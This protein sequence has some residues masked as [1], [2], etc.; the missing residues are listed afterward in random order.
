MKPVKA[1]SSLCALLALS[2]FPFSVYAQ[3]TPQNPPTPPVAQLPASG[4]SS[5]VVIKVRTSEV[6]LIFTVT[7]KHTNKSIKNLQQ[8]N[9]GLLDD[10][11]PPLRVLNFKQQTNLPLRVGIL[12]DTSSSVR[13]RFHFEQEAA[14]E[15]LLEILGHQDRA[16]VE[17]FDVGV[18]I[19][20][21]FTGNIDKL[22]QGIQKLRPGGGTALY[23]AIYKTCRDQLLPL[24]SQEATRRAIIL[25]SDGDDIYSHA[26]ESDAV[27]MCQRAE[28]IIYAISTNVG[29][30]K[31]KG[32]DVLKR[33]S[34]ETGGQTFFPK[35]IEDVALGFNS[36][37]DEL[38]SQYSLV[39]QPTD[40]KMDGAFRTIYLQAI[41][42]RYVV[43]VRKGYFAQKAPQ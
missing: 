14:T 6:N 1:T 19:S 25:V 17:G 40:F 13:T 37:R 35:R 4:D 12:L 10:G 11:K 38:R 22:N 33:M 42:P 23:D 34:E 32:D 27:K 20:Q 26:L 9:F 29:P 5:N 3:T 18:D 30:S 8:H 24:Q 7:D 21:D 39:Y 41:D 2:L 31:D 16:F 43:H 15:F 28:T 36:I